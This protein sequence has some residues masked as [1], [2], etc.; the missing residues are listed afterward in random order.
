M[1]LKASKVAENCFAILQGCHNFFSIDIIIPKIDED[2]WIISTLIILIQNIFFDFMSIKH[3]LLFFFN[4]V[5]DTK[6]GL[7]HDPDDVLIVFDL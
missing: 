1:L 2:V 3:I 7:L 5:S 6:S 4:F